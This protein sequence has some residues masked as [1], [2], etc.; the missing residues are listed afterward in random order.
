MPVFWLKPS[1]VCYLMANNFPGHLVA[2]S[3]STCVTTSLFYRYSL[4]KPT[5]SVLR[6][7]ALAVPSL[8]CSLS[9]IISH[10]GHFL[11]LFRLCSS[12]T[13][14]KRASRLPYP[15]THTAPSLFR[16]FYLQIYYY[17]K[18]S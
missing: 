11:S 7:F 13:S 10:M 1:V 9:Y 4:S 8:S 2:C 18:F 16:I 14:C 3:F 5:C 6:P 15:P 12:I 17:P